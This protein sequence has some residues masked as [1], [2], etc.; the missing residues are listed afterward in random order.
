[1]ATA[2]SLMSTLRQPYI[3]TAQRF[4]GMRAVV[5]GGAG[6]IGEACVRQLFAEGASVAILDILHV[7]GAAIAAELQ[8]ETLHARQLA[9]YIPC[10]VSDEAAV[11]DAFVRVE[12]ELAGGPDVLVCM[13]ANFVYRE[14]HEATGADWDRA[15]AVNVKGTAACVKAVIPGMR[16][17]GRGSIVL[18]S[19]I[20]GQLAFPGF[21]P[22]SATK[23]AIIQMVRDIALDNGRFGIRVNACAPGPIFTLGGT[24]AHSKQQG[25]DLEV[26][27]ADLASDV[28][29]KRMGTVQ[30]CAKAVAFLASADAAYITGTTL[31]VDG[32]FFRK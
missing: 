7:E 15:L 14:V 1:M 29:L 8:R 12:K 11:A 28:A 31:Q 20:T 9:V 24:V 26:L 6:G 16:T 3:G 17:R 27:C 13:A 25:V 18:T 5:T 19:S 21:V 22:Y 32:G 2:D 4:V 10:D 30:E 23:A